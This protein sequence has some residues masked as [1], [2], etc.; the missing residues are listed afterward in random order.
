MRPTHLRRRTP[1]ASRVRR[2]FSLVEV[3]VAVTIVALLA[4]I[5]APRVYKFIFKA[6]ASKAKTE[7]TTI[8]NQIKL[9]MTEYGISS[10]PAEFE[11]VWLTEGTSPYL[12]SKKDLLDPWGHDYVLRVPGTDGRDFDVMSY[13]ADGQAGGEGENADIVHGK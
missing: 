10:L 12:E 11:L 8:A 7:S 13:G 9:Y 2:A 5:V 1:S 4:A 3:I 6:N